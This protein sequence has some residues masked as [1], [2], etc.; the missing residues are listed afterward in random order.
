MKHLKTLRRIPVMSN[1]NMG[2]ANLTVDTNIPFEGFTND[3]TKIKK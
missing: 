3:E 1:L 2:K